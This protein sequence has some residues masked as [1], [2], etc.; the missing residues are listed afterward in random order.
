M[1]QSVCWTL[2]HQ[3]VLVAVKCH[4]EN[5]P[6]VSVIEAW[7]PRVA[8]AQKM[9][10]SYVRAKK[11]FPVRCRQRAWIGRSVVKFSFRL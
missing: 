4:P 1:I 11:I 9:I 8:L 2:P 6:S 3:R 10:G 5:N 7:R